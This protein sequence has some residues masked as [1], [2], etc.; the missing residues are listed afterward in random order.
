MN[1]KNISP[2]CGCLSKSFFL[3]FLCFS[4]L[5]SYSFCAGMLLFVCFLSFFTCFAT[6]LLALLLFLHL[7][8][9][10]PHLNCLVFLFFL[11]FL[12]SHRLDTTHTHTSHTQ[13]RHIHKEKGEG[14]EVLRSFSFSN[15]KLGEEGGRNEDRAS[16]LAQLASMPLSSPLISFL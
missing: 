1:E 9:P 15:Q 4:L 10:H 3:S 2:L 14:R 5:A 13:K 6:A 12:F 8:Y 7:T 16:I 11:S